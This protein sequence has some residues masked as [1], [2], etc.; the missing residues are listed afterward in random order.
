M[1]VVAVAPLGSG[2]LTDATAE[3]ALRVTGRA[4]LARVTIGG[5]GDALAAA[6]AYASLQNLDSALVKAL[7]NEVWLAA[8]R[9]S[10]LARPLGW[11]V[12]PG[13][14][15]EVP[16]ELRL[17]IAEELQDVAVWGDVRER[18]MANDC[19]PLVD[20]PAAMLA[21]TEG[22]LQIGPSLLAGTNR[23]WGII[24]ERVLLSD[25]APRAGL[26][27]ALAQ[28][29]TP[30]SPVRFGLINE[31]GV[32]GPLFITANFAALQLPRT[33]VMEDLQHGLNFV[34][35]AALDVSGLVRNMSAGGSTTRNNLPWIPE[36]RW[37]GPGTEIRE[38]LLV[39]ELAGVP[40]G[41]GIP[42][43]FVDRVRAQRAALGRPGTGYL[44]HLALLRAE[45]GGP[46]APAWLHLAKELVG[47]TP[48]ARP[49]APC[50]AASIH[51]RLVRLTQPP[52]RGGPAPGPRPPAPPPAPAPGSPGESGT[53]PRKRWRLFG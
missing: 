3:A 53:S 48:I 5:S 1:Q 22:Q 43:G 29:N 7:L 4:P 8:H 19:L 20:E 6:L 2:Q 23:A 47:M 51:M 9:F 17:G 38:Q 13:V 26:W 41:A 15:G 44:A 31:V 25:V 40:A 39:R 34:D 37:T 42:A 21:L 28:R 11:P 32:R 14:T 49:G 30:L 36:R 16:R 33:Q 46:A 12:V 24:V 18:L 50:A 27:R 45:S 52:P 10:E 35:D